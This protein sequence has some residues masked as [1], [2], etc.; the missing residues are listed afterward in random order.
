MAKNIMLAFVSVVSAFRVKNPVAYEKIQGAP[1]DSIQTN[2]SAIV[3]VERMLKK[4]SLSKILMIL[5][6]AK[7]NLARLHIWNF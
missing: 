6:K 4:N 7:Q 1:Y 3:Y 2:E 5:L